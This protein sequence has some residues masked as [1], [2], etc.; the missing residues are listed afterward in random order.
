MSWQA[1]A[2]AERQVTG[3]PSRKALLLVLANYADDRGISWPSQETIARGAELSVD[4][5]QR[6]SKKLAE[7]GLLAIKRLPK[8]RGQWQG[9]CYRLNLSMETRP[10]AEPQNAAWSPAHLFPQ[11]PSVDLPASFS[12]SSQLGLEKPNMRPSQA[13]E[14]AAQAAKLAVRPGRKACGINLHLNLQ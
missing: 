4:T 11:A 2:W 6:Q 12:P 7:L 3:H 13:A 1:T 10:Y 9:F 8:R 5:V 14:L